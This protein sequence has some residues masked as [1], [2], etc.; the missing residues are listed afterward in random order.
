MERDSAPLAEPSGSFEGRPLAN[1]EEPIFDQGLA[2]DLG[3]WTVGGSSS[4][5]GSRA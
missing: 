3:C 4:S 1:P 5:S 2:F